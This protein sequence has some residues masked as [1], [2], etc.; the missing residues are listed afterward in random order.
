MLKYSSVLLIY[1][2]VAQ[3]VEY[4]SPKPSVA[5]SIRVTPAI[6]LKG[7]RIYLKP[8]FLILRLAM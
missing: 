1:R 5:R 2:G 8:L 4:W 6:C 3:L 7:L